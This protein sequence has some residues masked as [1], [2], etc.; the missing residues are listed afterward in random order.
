M[1]TLNYRGF[2]LHGYCDRPDVRIS[3]VPHG[4]GTK[5]CKSLAAA[6]QYVGNLLRAKA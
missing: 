4:T 6:K 3:G 2:Y 1:W 5:E